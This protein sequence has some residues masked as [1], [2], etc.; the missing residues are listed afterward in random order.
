M[1]SKNGHSSSI[2]KTSLDPVLWSNSCN[3]YLRNLTAKQGRLIKQCHSEKKLSNL[4]MADAGNLGS[5]FY[6]LILI[7]I[8]SHIIFT[9]L[10]SCIASLKIHKNIA[11]E[12]TLEL[13]HNV[14]RTHPPEQGWRKH[15]Q[16]VKV[17]SHWF[18]PL[19]WWS[20]TGVTKMPML[21]KSCSDGRQEKASGLRPP[22]VSCA[23]FRLLQSAVI[24]YNVDVL[25]YSQHT[26]WLL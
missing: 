12:H 25:P 7:N 18:W 16:S 10:K 26:C 19:L 2:C 5:L 17:G 14:R 8:Y 21:T 24:L 13:V 11:Q 23:F 4:L 3:S 22:H 6:I 9:G 1:I 15:P 20:F